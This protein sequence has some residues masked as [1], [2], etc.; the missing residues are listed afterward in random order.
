MTGNNKLQSIIK[1]IPNTLTALNVFFGSLSILF[2]FEGELM[3]SAILLLIAYH[4]DIF[5]GLAARLLKVQSKIGKELDSLADVISFGLGPAAILFALM[6]TASG[7]DSINI[8]S[9]EFEEYYVF[10]PFILPV[11][12]ALRLAKFN[13]DEKNTGNFYGMPTP[14]NALF[15]LSIPLI[16]FNQPDSLLVSW[17]NSTAGI[18]G[19]S[20]IAS[21]LMVSNIPFYSMKIKGFSWQANKYTIVFL[22]CA[23]VIIFLF[24][25]NGLFLAVAFYLL[26]S[27]FTAMILRPKA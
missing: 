18:I 21:F 10:I 23:A 7:I 24:R 19:Y 1:H 3:Q 8:R 13:L 17:F 26:Y 5:D 9:L 14:A 22:A 20:I 4:C 27:F 6:K 2:A 16:S 15:I 12:A 11:F 25:Y